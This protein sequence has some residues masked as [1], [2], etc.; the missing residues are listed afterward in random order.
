MPFTPF[1]Q[2]LLAT[3]IHKAI[4]TLEGF[5][6]GDAYIVCAPRIR[7]SRAERFVRSWRVSEI[8]LLS[9]EALR[10]QFDRFGNALDDVVPILLDEFARR[11]DPHI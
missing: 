5:E 6:T 2:Q 3:I 9:E 4:L 10:E 8:P 11:G 7:G 1:Q